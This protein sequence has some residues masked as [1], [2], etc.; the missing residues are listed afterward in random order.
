MKKGLK[1]AEGADAGGKG[2]SKVLSKRES[3][4]SKQQAID[5]GVIDAKQ[6]E[7]K[8]QNDSFEKYYNKDLDLDEDQVPVVI[9]E[10]NESAINFISQESF[11][12]GLIL[13]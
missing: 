12:K 8:E 2:S 6:K 11:E 4:K 13:L 9:Y 3:K 1:G 5:T 7:D 10:L